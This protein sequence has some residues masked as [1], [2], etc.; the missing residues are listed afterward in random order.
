VNPDRQ[1]YLASL[2]EQ[3][4]AAQ[5]SGNVTQSIALKRHKYE[6]LRAIAAEDRKTK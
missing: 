4:E 2:D 5:S 6:T 3:I 1:S